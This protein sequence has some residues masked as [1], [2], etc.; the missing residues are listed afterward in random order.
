VKF[1][2]QDHFCLN[3]ERLVKSDSIPNEYRTKRNK[4]A[5]IRAHEVDGDGPHYFNV[6]MKDG[7]IM[8]FGCPAGGDQACQSAVVRARNGVRRS[9]MLQQV[10]DRQGNYMTYE[11]MQEANGAGEAA[12]WSPEDKETVE[13]L[14][15]SIKY[16]GHTPTATDPAAE[17]NFIYELRD[18]ER[19]GFYS[20][21]RTGMLHYLE[22]IETSIDGNLVKTYDLAYEQSASQ[23]LRLVSVQ[24]SD[25]LGVSKPPTKFEWETDGIGFEA[26]V[27]TGLLVPL[28]EEATFGAWRT[29]HIPVMGDVNGDGFTDMVYPVDNVIQIVF[30]NGSGY[31]TEYNTGLSIVPYN[32]VSASPVPFGVPFDYNQDGLL[33]ILLLHPNQYYEV[34]VSTGTTFVYEIT[35]VEVNIGGVN[36]Y[37]TYKNI[38]E[39]TYLVDLNGDGLQ[40]ILFCYK[41]AY[42]GPYQQW[43]YVSVS[44][45]HLTLP[46]TP[47][48]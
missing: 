38:K 33:D 31:D 17:V 4:M 43:Y 13:V 32:E 34:L 14:P 40:D 7:R 11:Y 36:P 19:H 26:E 28:N 35:D 2:D 23:R 37:P 16:T 20:G 45:T 44:Y 18:N 27:D 42:G 29:P 10:R 30:N 3:G 5:R 25:A 41:D 6:E 24:E 15:W 1:D 8:R 12:G 22:R 9:W 48:V 39:N 21:I 47:Y 46:T